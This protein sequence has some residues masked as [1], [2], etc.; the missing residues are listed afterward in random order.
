[1]KMKSSSS[2][3]LSQNGMDMFGER[4]MDWCREP[5]K[6]KEIKRTRPQKWMDHVQGT[7]MEL[8]RDGQ[9]HIIRQRKMKRFSFSS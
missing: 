4:V 9:K 6:K 3:E 7:I 2:R 5:K 1:M 8:S